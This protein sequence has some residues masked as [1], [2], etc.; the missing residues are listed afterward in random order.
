[1][2]SFCSLSFSSDYSSSCGSLEP[3]T[4]PLKAIPGPF[5][6]RFTS[7]WYFNRVRKGRFEYENIDL[8]RQYGPIVRVAPNQYSINDVSAI[9]IVYG[10]GTQFAKSA[11]YDGWKN[12][13]QWT[14]FSDRD[15]KRHA[16][17]RKRFT[18]LYSMSSL[19]HYEPFV[20]HCADL[21]IQRLTEFADQNQTFNLGHWFQCY[22]FDVIGNITFGDRFGFLDRGDDIDGAIAAVHKVMMYSTLVGIYPEWHP[23][24]F[25]LLG[26]LKSSG[27]AGRAYITK[28]VQEKIR[29]EEKK[30]SDAKVV[31]A[32]KGQMQ[33]FLEKMMLARDKDPEKVTDYHLLIMGQ[34]NVTAGSDTTAISLSS[35]MWY[36]LQNP[37]TLCKLRAEIDEFTA[38]GR[39]SANVTFKESQDMPY[40]QAVMKE[41]LRMHSATGLPMWRVVPAGGAQ[42]S[43]EFFPAGTIVGANT[44]VAHYDERIFPNANVFK[45]ER[46]IEAENHPE[47]LKEMNQMYMPFGLGSRTCLGKHISIL[48]MS[49]LI[50]RLV[51]DFNFT[52]LRK[53][54][55]TANYWFVKPT[56]FEVQVK[57]RQN[58]A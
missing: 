45:P 57:E 53:T 49:K 32:E 24:L 4:P 37:E 52:P 27:A 43:G 51:R 22:A 15:I 12:P 30:R 58:K 18:S 42:I 29:L 25:G 2:P 14:V 8:H 47:Q 19:V 44:W 34:S 16:D 36:L 10:A 55:Q 20:D 33:N 3:S 54:W 9:K 40:F 23:R 1:M 35:I 21:F 56:D 26:K 5:W 50:P 28:F 46:W 7:L 11:W 13:A 31:V 17:T 38:Q 48:E 6:A 41:A 39:C